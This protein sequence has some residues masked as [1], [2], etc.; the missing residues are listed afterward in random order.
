MIEQVRNRERSEHSHLQ[1]HEGLRAV[2]DHHVA[3]KATVG[4]AVTMHEYRPRKQ[5]HL[6]LILATSVVD[7]LERRIELNA[8]IHRSAQA[9]HVL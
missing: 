4:S 1:G 5:R 2:P 6:A 3:T 9:F 8:A 7:K